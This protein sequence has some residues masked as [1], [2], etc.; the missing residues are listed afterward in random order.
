MPIV[1]QIVADIV[2]AMFGL[3]LHT[4]AMFMGASS[5]TS[6]HREET[7]DDCFLCRATNNLT[8]PHHIS[9]GLEWEVIHD[10]HF[11]IV[12]LEHVT[13]FLREQH[14]NQNPQLLQ[15]TSGY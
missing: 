6:Y 12:S 15:H 2:V 3:R 10:H 8:A 5:G 14:P 11:Q 7:M 4:M 1:V 13:G 9:E